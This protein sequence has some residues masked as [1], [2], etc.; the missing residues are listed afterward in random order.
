MRAHDWSTSPLGPPERWP[1]SLRSV[2]GL[3][4]NS[5][6]PMFVAW[7]RDLGFLY[8][9]A[10]AEILAGKHPRSLGARFYDIWSEIWPD[11]WPLIEAAM[12]GRAIYRENLPLT[13]NRK[14][15]DEQ[16]WFTFSYSPVRHESGAVAGMFCAVEETTT[17]ILADQRLIASEARYRQ[18]AAELKAA[19]QATAALNATLEHRIED[20]LAER[21]KDQARLVEAQESLRQVQKMETI[22][23][24]T[25]GVAHDFNNLLTPIVG[26]LDVLRRQTT[27][28]ERAQRLAS[29]ALQAADRAR[30]MIQRLLAFS[31]RQHL[32][33]LAVDIRRLIAGFA[34]LVA[35]L[36]GPRVELRLDVADDLPLALVD[37]NQL[38]LALLN[39]AVNGR[40]AMAGEGRLT[41]AARAHRVGDRPRL[42]AGSYISIAVSDTGT[43]MDD[44]TLRRATEPFF[45]TKGV[46]RG[47]GLGLSSV[48]GLAEQS[49]GDFDIESFPGRGTT[50]T[51][52]LPLAAQSASEIAAG[53]D[54]DVAPVHGNATPVLLVDDEQL[55]RV[56]TADM[57]AEAG[58]VVTQAASGY[59]ALR[60]LED[61]LEVEAL[62]S[63]FAMPGMSGLELAQEA[64]TLRPNL[65]VLLVTGYANV[66]ESEAGGLAR[67]AKP[68]RQADLAAAVADLLRDPKII[69]LPRGRARSAV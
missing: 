22:G 16:T 49:G 55:V 26:A 57:L 8:N 20:A 58:Y 53:G 11:I 47:T 38:E 21:L 69:R 42:A 17:Q 15:F 37:P 39:L 4:L 62:I 54:S 10:Y 19:Q 13:M 43:G 50:A 60:L 40:D 12:A 28:D 2:V 46:G 45:T 23:Q 32:E 41:I 33:P 3:L 51:L 56:G 30:L 9:D 64:L 48:L 7:G 44:E 52:W 25:G 63:D 18:L 24:L 67:L 34:D 65:Q 68:F 59:E 35:R 27:G 31:R 61:G 1:Q 6:F 29:G 5:K 36:L 66:A 14:G